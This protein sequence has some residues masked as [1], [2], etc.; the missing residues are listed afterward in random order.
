MYYEDKVNNMKI[1]TITTMLN[2]SIS[3]T[4]EI[5]DSNIDDIPEIVDSI[6]IKLRIVRDMVG[7]DDE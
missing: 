5:L 4:D 2:E 3:L 1:T 7:E 6:I